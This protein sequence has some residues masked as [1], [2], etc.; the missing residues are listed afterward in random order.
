MTA[1]NCFDLECDNCGFTQEFDDD[2]T[3]QAMRRAESR[4]WFLSASGLDDR[5]PVCAEAEKAVAA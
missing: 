3:T 2:T 5:C 1:W 4:G